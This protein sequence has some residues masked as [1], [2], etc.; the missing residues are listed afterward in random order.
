MS[1]ERHRGIK[2]TVRGLPTRGGSSDVARSKVT[3]SIE[4]IALILDS[5]KDV[6]AYE[7]STTATTA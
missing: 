2:Y 7:I 3:T 1:S 5:G 6:C 4:D